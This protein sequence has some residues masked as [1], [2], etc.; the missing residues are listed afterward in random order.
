MTWLGDKVKLPTEKTDALIIKRSILVG[1][2]QDMQKKTGT[3]KSQAATNGHLED[4][5]ALAKQITS[6]DKKLGRV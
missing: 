1:K 5:T 4:L 2:I 6:I 3:H